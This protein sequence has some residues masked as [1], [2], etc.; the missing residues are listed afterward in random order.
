[1]N[2]YVNVEIEKTSVRIRNSFAHFASLPDFTL[3]KTKERT[4]AQKITKMI[5]TILQRY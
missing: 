4:Q 3:N 1:M 5:N 2:Q